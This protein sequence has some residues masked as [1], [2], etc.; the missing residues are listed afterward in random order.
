VLHTQTFRK[1]FRTYAGTLLETS[2]VEALT[3]HTGGLNDIK[4]VYNRYGSDCEEQLA[5]DFLKIEHLLMLGT[6]D[7]KSETELRK[8]IEEN[9]RAEY[10]TELKRINEV[11]DNL[12]Q[13]VRE[14][15][16]EKN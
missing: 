15:A 7:I 8:Q 13:K 12:S 10:E 3:G 6:G 14:Y 5:K 1:Y 2:V 16:K 11:I 9:I 4:T